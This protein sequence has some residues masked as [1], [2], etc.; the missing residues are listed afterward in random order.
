M[1]SKVVK[2]ICYHFINIDRNLFDNQLLQIYGEL[3]MLQ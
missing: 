2:S 1:Y 3:M